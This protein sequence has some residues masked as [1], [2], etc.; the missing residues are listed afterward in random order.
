MPS[1]QLILLA[2]KTISGI[3]RSL[4]RELHDAELSWT[5]KDAGFDSWLREM[6]NP[7][8]ATRRDTS[9]ALGFLLSPRILE[10]PDG[11]RPQIDSLLGVL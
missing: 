4:N 7:D 9:A 1:R 2:D 3:E 6:M 5:V 10:L 8:S 11:G